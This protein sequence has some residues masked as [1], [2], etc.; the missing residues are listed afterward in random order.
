[1]PTIKKYENR[2]L[3]D[4]DG[5]RYVN[6]DD[7]ASM[8]RRGESVSVVDSRTGRDL[9]RETLLHVLLAAE[10]GPDLLP[11]G[12]LRR[13]IRATGTDPLQRMLRPHVASGLELMHAQLDEL[14]GKM[15]RSFPHLGPSPFTPP[16]PPAPAPPPA[17]PAPVAPPAPPADD[18]IDELRQRLDALEARLKRG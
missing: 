5:S 16:P 14:E 12:M 18:D 11:V 10:G 9:T 7:I 13:V 1:M 15:L 4:A 8:V 2:R 6:L 3:Y 17:A